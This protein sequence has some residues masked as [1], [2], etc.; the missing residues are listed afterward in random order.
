M[1]VKYILLVVATCSLTACDKSVNR[2]EI[3][4]KPVSCENSFAM[5]DS[6]QV[7]LFDFK[8]KGEEL[9]QSFHLKYDQQ[10]SASNVNYLCQTKELAVGYAFRG[11]SGGDAG[12]DF[13][14]EKDFYNIE[15]KP[16]SFGL[17]LTIGQELFVY[18]ALVKRAEIDPGIGAMTKEEYA[19]KS[20]SPP[21]QVF[22][23]EKPPSADSSEH[24][25]IDMLAINLNS[26]KV[27][28]K[29]RFPTS[30]G[31]PMWVEGDN[32]IV[33]NG[34]PLAINTQNGHRKIKVDNFNDLQAFHE[35]RVRGHYYNNN[36]YVIVGK[37]RS[38][39]TE[40]TN[41]TPDSIYVHNNS[42]SS[43]D[44]IASLNFDPVHVTGFQNEIV[45]FGLGSFARFDIAKNKL[46]SEK[47]NF[48]GMEV[49][50]STRIKDGRVLYLS[51]PGTKENT[52]GGGEL[53]VY[54]SAWGKVITKH[55]FD[56]I[57]L[58]SITSQLSSFPSEVSYNS[59]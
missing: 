43:W 55:K 58:P 47:R 39:S 59:L 40:K 33:Y 54:D 48:E 20:M 31:L 42:T 25:Y 11:K 19:P 34:T 6:Q 35:F 10:A 45:I 41:I 36:F 26:H 14:G 16:D 57:G 27:D 32:F 13:I 28:R 4:I 30:I 49:T 24:V 51:H 9:F 7:W 50:A 15:I 38:D 12:I 23:E 46:V 1:I 44:K 29:L 3:R 53:W 8:P 17:M 56:D 52:Y 5:T 22:R 18:T 2:T 21:S 37:R